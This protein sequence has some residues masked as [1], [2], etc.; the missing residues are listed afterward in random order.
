MSTQTVNRFL[1]GAA[2]YDEYMPKDLDRIDTDMAMMNHAGINVIRIAESTWSTC[3][4]Q[5][6]IFD[7]SHVDRALD[8]AHRHGISVIVGTPTYAVPTWLVR[9][10]PDVL[11]VTPNGPGKYGPRQIMD[12]VNGSYRYY[13]ERVIRKLIAHVANHP[14]VIGYQVDNETKYYDCVSPDMQALFVKHL[15]ERF[16]DN[17]DELNARFGLDYWSN[18]INAWE[19]FPDVTNTINQ[20]LRGAFDRF[21]REQVSE[22]LA[23]Q[24]DIVREYARDDQFITQNFDFGWKGSSYGV[25]PAVDHFKAART[26]DIAGCDIYHPTQD[27]LTGKEIAFGGDLTRSLKDG[28]NY[29]VLETEAQGNHGWLPFP[30]QM[31]LQAYSHLASGADMVE[32]WHW[33][34]IHNSFETYWKGLLSHDLEPNSTYEEAGVFGREIARAQISERLLHLTKHNNVAIM[35]SNEA[36]TALEGFRI[37]SGTRWGGG[38]DYNDVVRRIYDA[39]FELNVECDFLPDD[40]SAERLARYS[41]IV[42]PALYCASDETIAQLRDYVANGGHL[43]ATLRSFVSDEETTVWHDRAPHNLT[44]VFGMSYNQITPPKG[45]V[46]VV[47]GADKNVAGDTAGD[48]TTVPAGSLSL[49]GLPDA[50][51]DTLIELLKPNG[52]ARFDAETADQ[53]APDTHTQVLAH[54]GHYAW[55]DYAA[56]TRHAFGKGSAEWIGTILDADATRAVLREAL[57]NAD[58]AMPFVSSAVESATEP[59]VE[60]PAE[61]ATAINKPSKPAV[62]PAVITVRQGTNSR[63]ETVTYLLNYS[64]ES[65]TFAS[66]VAGEVVVAPKIIAVNG[67]IDETATAELNLNEGDRVT[68]GDELTLPR[69][70][71]AVIAS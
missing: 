60:P 21:R 18:R 69:W 52:D 63:G 8:S 19:D 15:R 22:F 46:P 35:V 31:R 66:P 10:H 67:L 29:L 41:V 32:Y 68:S 59:A 5:P 43:I 12:I 55:T 38:A 61:S 27:D 36:L 20:S 34:S 9:M 13:A 26:L 17:L 58:V 44:D 64:A 42:T 49:A 16:H 37:G 6:G 23:W 45:H 56:I 54:Y 53:P 40:A 70:N 48:S 30:G 2:Y 14:A 51:A 1:F 7:W 28:A 65:V 3:E 11:A 50:Q 25:Q 71:L 33:H 39:L 57:A 4:P 47:F 24:A 62:A